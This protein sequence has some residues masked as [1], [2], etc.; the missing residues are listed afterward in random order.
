[1]LKLCPTRPEPIRD[2]QGRGE[3][4]SI[5]DGLDQ[6]GRRLLL[7]H[8]R[9]VAEVNSGPPAARPDTVKPAGLRPTGRQHDEQ[10]RPV[11]QAESSSTTKPP[12]V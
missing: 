10:A 2:A 4:V 1:M 7:A 11:A 9:A 6:E 3:L 12:S 5:W 8:A